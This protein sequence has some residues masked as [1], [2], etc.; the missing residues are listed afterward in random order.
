MIRSLQNLN[1]YRYTE[2]VESSGAYQGDAGCIAF[3]SEGIKNEEGY[4]NFVDVEAKMSRSSTATDCEGTTAQEFAEAYLQGRDLYTNENGIWK[5]FSV[6]NP[7]Q[8]LMEMDKLGGIVDIISG[9][10]NIVLVNESVDEQDYYVLKIIPSE[11][12]SLQIIEPLAQAALSCPHM[13]L[14]NA[15]E[16]LWNGENGLME[17]SEMAWTVWISTT[18]F[19]PRKVEGEVRLHL[20]PAMFKASPDVCNL[21]VEIYQKN[22]M[23]FHSFDEPLAISLPEEAIKA[24]MVAWPE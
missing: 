16:G 10:E 22:S 24:E 12:S 6:P 17:N 18:D 11:S 7:E 3:A 1:S 8:V 15:D 2:G 23:L 20:T 19:L 9:S 4:L 14:C 21:N 5:R 13:A